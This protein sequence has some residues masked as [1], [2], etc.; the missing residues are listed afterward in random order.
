MTRDMM[1]Q[2]KCLP[3]AMLAVD[4]GRHVTCVMSVHNAECPCLWLNKYMEGSQDW[5]ELF[6]CYVYA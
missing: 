2:T 6:M 4:D 3:D 1:R 5:T